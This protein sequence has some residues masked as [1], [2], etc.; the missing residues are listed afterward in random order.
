MYLS[1]ML[2]RQPIVPF[3][4]EG[5]FAVRAPWSVAARRLLDY[6]LVYIQEGECLFQVD[7]AP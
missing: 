4:R 2:A 1:E 5:D 7:G 3:I 6:L